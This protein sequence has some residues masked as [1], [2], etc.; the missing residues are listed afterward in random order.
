MDIK[1]ISYS[2]Y[3]VRMSGHSITIKII[4]LEVVTVESRI[5]L[6]KP[7]TV[8]YIS[9]ILSGGTYAGVR[10]QGA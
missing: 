10:I 8:T 2:I 6:I 1:D 7:H 5:S 4:E 9:T 3:L